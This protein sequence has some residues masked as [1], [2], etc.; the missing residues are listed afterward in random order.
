[1]DSVCGVAWSFW[2]SA[3]S[4]QRLRRVPVTQGHESCCW[5][6]LVTLRSL[7]VKS[8]SGLGDPWILWCFSLLLSVIQR[9]QTESGPSWRSWSGSSCCLAASVFRWELWAK[10]ESFSDQKENTLCLAFSLG[11][12]QRRSCCSYTRESEQAAHMHTHTTPVFPATS[13]HTCA[14]IVL[15]QEGL[16]RPGQV[17]RD[18]DTVWAADPLLQIRLCLS[19]SCEQTRLH[20]SNHKRTCTYSHVHTNTHATTLAN[21]L[22]NT[23]SQK[24]CKQPQNVLTLILKHTLM[25]KR[26]QTQRNNYMC[27]CT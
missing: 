16:Y 11:Q 25:H 18:H 1:M 10:I 4:P 13:S 26:T 9:V 23:W 19:A 12:L 3:G 8:F 22:V 5:S 14:L 7:I 27:T 21:V 15:F 20:T 24:M 2:R 6:L 17:H